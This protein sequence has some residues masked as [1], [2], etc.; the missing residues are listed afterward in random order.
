M[1]KSPRGEHAM[2]SN[3]AT[4]RCLLQEMSES[5]DIDPGKL[6]CV[7]GQLITPEG[8]QAIAFDLDAGISS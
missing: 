3:E 5:L 2:E 8:N 4:A 6:A 1:A 7:E